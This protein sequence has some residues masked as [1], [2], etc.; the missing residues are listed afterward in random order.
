MKFIDICTALYD[1]QSQSNEELSFKTY[2]IL[3]II[4]KGNAD[5]FKA[6]VKT[7]NGDG[8]SG[9]V[10]TNYIEKTRPIGIAKAL[11]DYQPRS[12]DELGFKEKSTMILYDKEDSDWYFAKT[13]D[14]NY[15]L[16]PS[17]YIENSS[18]TKNS[19]SIH[20]PKWGI[21]LYSFSPQDQEETQLQEHE[22]VLVLDYVSNQD[23]WTVRHKGGTSGVV[24]AAYIE[25]KDKKET[26]QKIEKGDINR[27]T[28][29]NKELEKEK[30]RQLEA[31]RRRK[32]QEES[33][34]KE[35]EEKKRQAT[36]EAAKSLPSTQTQSGSPRRSETSTPLPP[37]VKNQADSDI[38]SNKPNC[39][40]VR[41]WTDR[42][43]AFKVEAELLSCNNGKI[44]L[45]KSNGVKIDVP[46]EKMCIEDLQYI[47]R[48][49]GQKLLNSGSSPSQFSW[50]DYF[51]KINIPYDPSVRYAKAFQREGFGEKD[52]EKFTYG[53][54]KSL[55]MAEKHVRRL[56]RFIE[57]N[58][59]EPIS[60]DESSK[61]R[62]Q[63]KRN[64]T[65]GPV[66]YIEDYAVIVNGDEETGGYLLF[67]KKERDGQFD[68]VSQDQEIKPINNIGLHRRA[69]GRSVSSL[70]ALTAS[71]P[72][73]ITSTR[74]N[75]KF[76]HPQPQKQLLL[77]SSANHAASLSYNQSTLDD[78]AWT[79]RPNPLSSSKQL[80]SNSTFSTGLVS[81]CVQPQILPCQR[82]ISQTSQH[83]A[84][85][86]QLL[87][88][89]E[90]GLSLVTSTNSVPSNTTPESNKP[91]SVFSQNSSQVLQQQ[92]MTG[93][94]S[95]SLGSVSPS[96]QSQSI[97]SF[98]QE[99]RSSS[100]FDTLNVGNNN[101]FGTSPI[102]QG[103]TLEQPGVFASMDRG[104]TGSSA[105]LQNHKT[106]QFNLHLSEND[107]FRGTPPQ[108]S[109]FISPSTPLGYF[110]NNGSS[111]QAQYTKPDLTPTGPA[112]LQSQTT[113]NRSWTTATPDNPFGNRVMSVPVLQANM[114]SFNTPLT[115]EHSA[116]TTDPNDKYAVFKTINISSSSILKPDALLQQQTCFNPTPTQQYNTTFGNTHQYQW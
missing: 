11:Y 107:S 81:S 76:V 72:S 73:T 52:L 22:E 41:W 69:T 27:D 66:T 61:P 67:E 48:M 32:M 57:T 29:L 45:F 114:H 39:T 100:Q 106:G 116:N 53:K 28:Q 17:N 13:D 46:V 85:D 70:P 62:L 83:R 79:P 111:V 12:T 74:T 112:P 91:G 31:E 80:T 93:S 44:K 94:Y 92:Q 101:H 87:E 16:V 55:G 18:D 96:F 108:P 15:G 60:D 42:T 50:L 88:S 105:S 33:R 115:T 7:K 30:L 35:N 89:W 103:Q 77:P 47:E 110:Q 63:K 56:Q 64:V 6:Q 59:A 51:K 113:S 19:E 34:Q 9:L 5:W 98:Q 86:S 37:L 84:A 26:E 75:Q 97:P 65:F 40:K 58:H 54:M 90:K 14:G 23:W 2:D 3:Y 82:P 102:L 71:D 25:F 4:E 1:Y 20:E 104:F 43:G 21:A 49:T 10:P 99:H 68:R 78:D 38:D 109:S 36:I 95:V 8:P 24:P